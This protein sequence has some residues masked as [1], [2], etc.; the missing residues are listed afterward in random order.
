MHLGDFV[1]L[2]FATLSPPKSLFILT[3]MIPG[4][5]CDSNQIDALPRWFANLRRGSGKAVKRRRVHGIFFFSTFHPAV[6]AKPP[7]SPANIF[8]A[9]LSPLSCHFSHPVATL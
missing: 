7:G 2:S 4:G 8:A 3:T 5:N 1:R 6:C 9:S